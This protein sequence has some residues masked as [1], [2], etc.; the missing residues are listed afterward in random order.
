VPTQIETTYDVVGLGEALLHLNPRDQQL[1]EQ[2]T[3]LEIPM[4]D[5]ETN[6]LVGLARSACGRH[7]YYV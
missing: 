5:S 7:G 2:A 6:V 4:G 3:E 1:L